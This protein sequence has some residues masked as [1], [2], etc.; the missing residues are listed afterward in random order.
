[1]ADALSR[2][3]HLLTMLKNEKV[4]FVVLLEQYP[5]DE[6]FSNVWKK[7]QEGLPPSDF[8]VQQGFLFKGNTLCIPRSSLREH[9]IRE[10][11]SNG[12]AA[13]PGWGKTLSVLAERFYWPRM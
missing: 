11:H 10:L 3:V 13:H 4:G 12:M 6:D 1:M 5:L 2:R 8:H 9:C 7:C